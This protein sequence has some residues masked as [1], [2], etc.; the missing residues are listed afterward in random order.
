MVWLPCFYP[1]NQTPAG[2]ISQAEVSSR[3]L[4]IICKVWDPSS[5]FYKELTNINESPEWST[6][7]PSSIVHI[8]A[9]DH[10]LTMSVS[11]LL[12]IHVGRRRVL[13]WLLTESAGPKMTPST[14]QKRHP[15]WELLAMNYRSW[16]RMGLPTKRGPN[17]PR[18]LQDLPYLSKSKPLIQEAQGLIRYLRP[19]LPLFV[20]FKHSSTCGLAWA[21]CQHSVQE[22]WWK[23]WFLHG[24]R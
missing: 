18:T 15:P 3:L 22:T 10:R 9:L 1:T 24:R 2:T 6:R 4:G 14:G 13:L 5:L 21:P 20:P 7:D 19:A 16:F 11:S 17:W 12:S 23:H 8:P